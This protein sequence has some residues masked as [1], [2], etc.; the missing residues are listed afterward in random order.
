LAI[1]IKA[2]KWSKYIPTTLIIAK[3]VGCCAKSAE[4]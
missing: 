4:K 1:A 3:K 2:K